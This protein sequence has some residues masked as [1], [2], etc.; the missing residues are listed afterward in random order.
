LLGSGTNCCDGNGNPSSEDAWFRVRIHFPA[1]YRPTPYAQNA[2]FEWHNDDVSVA[3]ARAVGENVYSTLVGVVADGSCNSDLY[4]PTPGTNPRWY[5]QVT[6]GNIAT[7]AD[8]QGS[9]IQNRVGPG[10][11]LDHWYDVVDHLRTSADPA[12]GAAEVWIDGVK[13]L[14]EHRPTQ[15][16]RTDGT[17]GYGENFGVTNDRLSCSWDA[18]VDFDE[19]VVGPTA[20]SVGFAP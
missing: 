8:A 5:F 16:R 17:Y 13:V 19:L 2:L 1:D 15:F 6:G 20:T 18:S 12:I 7:G 11:V 9:L 14:D 4:C 10:V 3:N